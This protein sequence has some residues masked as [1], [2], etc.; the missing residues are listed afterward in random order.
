[1]SRERMGPCCF[2]VLTA[3]LWASTTHA[4]RVT[5]TLRDEAGGPAAGRLVHFYHGKQNALL[6][7]RTDAQGRFDTGDG[8]AG[9]VGLVL[10]EEADGGALSRVV[11]LAKGIALGAD[12]T[13]ELALKLAPQRATAD[14]E[15]ALRLLGCDWPVQLTSR[16]IVLDESSS[17]PDYET[18]WHGAPVQVADVERGGSDRVTAYRAYARLGVRI[19]GEALSWVTDP[20]GGGLIDR[21]AEGG[22]ELGNSRLSLLIPDG[23]DPS[24]APIMRLKGP[25]GRWFGRGAW[26]GPVWRSCTVARLASGPVFLRYRVTYANAA[27]AEYAVTITLSEGDDFFRIDEEA[28]AGLAGHWQLVLTGEG[29]APDRLR[30][31]RHYAA[32]APVALPTRERLDPGPSVNSRGRVDSWTVLASIQPW[33]FVGLYDYREAVSVFQAAGREDAVSIFSVDGAAWHD[34]RG[35]P[36]SEPEFIP[37]MGG[38]AGWPIA[39]PQ[40]TAK[41]LCGDAGAVAI[42]Y[43]IQ[44]GRRVTGWAVYDKGYDRAR[45]KALDARHI[46]SDTPLTDVLA[47]HLAWEAPIASPLLHGGEEEWGKLLPT[48]PSDPTAYGYLAGRRDQIPALRAN[49]FRLCD[50]MLRY[51]RYPDPF[52]AEGDVLALDGPRLSTLGY[53]GLGQ[54]AIEVGPQARNLAELADFALSMGA[55]SAEEMGRVR[56]VLAFTAY[57][58]SDVD[59]YP[60]EHLLGNFKIDGYFGLMLVSLMLKDHPDFDRFWDNYLRQVKQDVEEGGYIAESGAINEAPIYAYMSMNFLTKQQWYLR[61]HGMDYD[62]ASQ[63]R[64]KAALGMMAETLTPPIPGFH[65]ATARVIP[66]FGDTTVRDAAHLGVF[67]YAAKDYEESDPLFA[68]KMLWT[69]EMVGRPLFAGHGIGCTVTPNRM[70]TET[71]DGQVRLARS[72]LKAVSPG[73][74]ESRVIEG[75]GLALRKAW[76]TPEEFMFLMRTGGDWAHDHP[77]GGGFL[78]FAG[79]TCITTGY[80]K[81]PYTTHS[82]RYSLVRLGGRSNWSRG[83][84]MGFV[85]SDLCDAATTRIVTDLMSA[86]PE[87]GLREQWDEQGRFGHETL[88]ADVTVGVSWYDRSVIFN[89]ADQYLVIYDVCAPRYESDWY[90]HVASDD[91]TASGSTVSLPG[92]YGM[93]VDIHIVKPADAK[94]EITPVFEKLFARELASEEGPKPGGAGF[95]QTILEMHQGPGAEYLAVWHPRAA[96]V[97]PPLEVKMDGVLLVKGESGPSLFVCEKEAGEYGLGEFTV[98]GTQGYLVRSGERAVL[99]LLDGS[100]VAWGPY[101][102]HSTPGVRFQANFVSARLTSIQSWAPERSVLYIAIRTS[103]PGSESKGRL[104]GLPIPAGQSS[105]VLP[106]MR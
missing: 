41:L 62:I 6:S 101:A 7:V 91:Y 26:E 82:R 106:R 25:D 87:P 34:G 40:T 29:Y 93:G 105:Y 3:L 100:E 92:R 89:R 45:H 88:E 28:S 102:F 1:M 61:L 53:V 94:P 22:I 9:G 39:S 24:A 95:S 74:Y 16:R 13:R 11:F 80:G 23:T 99:G 27:G 54:R 70:I 77:E 79:G 33:T 32:N 57:K 5:G 50:A 21:K 56:A 63:P 64:F 44:P 49:I 86:G 36:F 46:R 8:L 83:G 42:R 17:E 35:V 51:Y 37:P 72:R 31:Y 85:H 98:R 75:F 55:L 58:L 84:V 19:E 97:T 96:G 103:E 52:E 30:E 76:N 60:C 66:L 78:L 10:A 81:Y 38:F 104:I 18:S 67:L 65:D 2:V 59:L 12:E 48:D 20:Q 43:P 71:V 68:G 69:W 4:A 90:A 15:E 47:M 14:P 73:P